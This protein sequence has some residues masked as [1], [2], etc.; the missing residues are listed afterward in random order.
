MT[1]LPHAAGLFDGVAL[2]R[3]TLM[4]AVLDD[5]DLDPGD[6]GIVL[7]G[8][9]LP[10]SLT[11]GEL[12]EAVGHEDE[13]TARVR[14]LR[15][16]RARRILADATAED[17]A[18]RLRPVGY[19]VDH[20][21]H[22]GRDWVQE[23]VLGGALDLGYGVAGLGKDPDAVEVLPASACAAAGVRLDDA[24]PGARRYLERMGVVAA[25]RLLSSGT[26]V[27]RPMGDCD[28]VTL[29]GARSW[30]VAVAAADG[31]GMRGVAVPMR[32]RGWL[33]LRRVDP[34]FVA[35]AAQATDVAERGFSRP[36]L[37]TADEVALPRPSERLAAIDLRDPA[38]SSHGRRPVRWR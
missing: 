4:V 25:E 26:S 20:P 11:W 13:Q 31:T 1:P 29:L 3:L 38:P 18:L 37:V 21:H 28:V 34:A 7:C 27:L 10:L 33:D 19:A 9:G 22:P 16:L 8:S 17:L 14:L 6:T 35:A 36:L 5:V 30:R 2:R 32:Q 15:H 12:R 23:A 24:W